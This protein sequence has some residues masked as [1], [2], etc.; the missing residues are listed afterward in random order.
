MR[1]SC[2]QF[3]V[4]LLPESYRRLSSATR[5]KPLFPPPYTARAHP[6]KQ[7]PIKRP[8]TPSLTSR[9]WRQAEARWRPLPRLR[10]RP[11]RSP[12]QVLSS[13]R[14]SAGTTLRRPVRRAFTGALLSMP[15]WNRNVQ[16][17][18]INIAQQARSSSC[19]WSLIKEASYTHT[20]MRY[21]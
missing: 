6:W 5:G 12:S 20:V 19:C 8:P 11:D 21:R 1:W 2:L 13:S 7:Y 14:K 3:N 16:T 18:I 10:P 4:L 15:K 9:S 17:E